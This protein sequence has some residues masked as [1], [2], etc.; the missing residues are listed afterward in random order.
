MKVATMITPGYAEDYSARS[1]SRSG[2]AYYYK[3]QSNTIH[4]W[5]VVESRC[6]SNNHIYY[7][8]IRETLTGDYLSESVSENGKYLGDPLTPLDYIL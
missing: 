1:R 6:N 4:N 5:G 7:K 8:S 2:G 3:S